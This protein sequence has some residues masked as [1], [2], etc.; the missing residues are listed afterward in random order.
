MIDNLYQFQQAFYFVIQVYCIL[1][2]KCS[3]NWVHM[4]GEHFHREGGWQDNDLPSFGKIKDIIVIVGSVLLKTEGINNHILAY[5]IIRTRQSFLVCLSSI[6]YK[7]LSGHTYPGD[8]GLYMFTF[9]CSL[10]I[11]IIVQCIRCDS[12]HFF[13]LFIEC[14]NLLTNRMLALHV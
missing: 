13:K 2:Q 4:Y 12:L 5:L 11:Q 8:R 10:L 6:D 7:V 1:T 3:P 14:R 9:S